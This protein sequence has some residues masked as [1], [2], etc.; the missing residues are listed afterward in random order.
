[1]TDIPALADMP[2]GSWVPSHYRVCLYENSCANIKFAKK[3]NIFFLKRI[4]GG[5]ENCRR[6]VVFSSQLEI[7]CCGRCKAP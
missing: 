4:G 1:M 7:S 5:E 2:N 6:D 3:S